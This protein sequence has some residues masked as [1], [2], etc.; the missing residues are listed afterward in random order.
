MGTP[1][2]PARYLDGPVPAPTWEQARATRRVCAAH[3][4][5]A[6]DLQL[7]LKA[8]AITDEDMHAKRCVHCDEQWAYL[9][10]HHPCVG[11][12]E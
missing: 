12:E 11:G 3:A 10:D 6:E 4:K 1:E 5:D 2:A 7:L 9:N 8:L